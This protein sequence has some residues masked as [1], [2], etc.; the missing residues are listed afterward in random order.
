MKQLLIL[1]SIFLSFSSTAQDTISLSKQECEGVFLKE[2]LLLIAEQLKISQAEALVQQAK[3]WPN[4]S[5]SM[6]EVNLWA[7]NRQTGGEEVSPPIFG[8]WGKNQQFAMEIEQVILTAGKRKKLMALEQVGVDKASV[9]FEELLRNLKTEFRSLLAELQYAQKV[10]A[11][12]NEQLESIRK[13][14]VSYQSQVKQGNL[15]KGEYVRL[16]ALELELTSGLNELKSDR[17]AVQKEL[18]SLMRL[19]PEQVLVITD[20][21]VVLQDVSSLK[22]A[23]LIEKAREN[24]HDLKLAGLEKDY[25]TKLYAYERSQRVP[26]LSLKMNYDRNGNT[27]LDFVGLGFA[28]DLPFFNRNQGNIN[29]AKTGMEV[30][31]LENEYTQLSVENEVVA[32]YQD[33]LI[34]YDFNNSIE[35]DYEATLDELL[36][37]YTK[38]FQNRN[39]GMVEFIDFLDAYLDNKKIIL[40]AEKNVYQKIEELNYAVG[41]EVLE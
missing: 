34:A 39:I 9:Y 11:A 37:H 6:D 33:L 3:L 41:A 4:P 20:S 24:R 13:L 17:N 25:Y 28:I 16:K 29:Y 36:K 40:D 31:K 2:N 38:N 27:M 10:E 30:A 35:E 7:T 23:D 32:A 19:K 12:Y 5:F 18:K 26:D 22:A 8:K 15:S 1:L 21:P 14:T